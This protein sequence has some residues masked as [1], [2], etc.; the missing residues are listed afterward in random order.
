V[1]TDYNMPGL[2][3]TELAQRI[4]RVRPTQPIVLLSGYGELI[5]HSEITASGVREYLC[6]PVRMQEL[7][8]VLRRVLSHA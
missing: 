2:K 8:E 3:G 1:I 4:R 7:R 6:K 5:D